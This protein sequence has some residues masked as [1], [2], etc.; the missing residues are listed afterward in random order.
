[1]AICN[2]QKQGP[3][4]YYPEVGTKLAPPAIYFSQ[5]D[6]R[7]YH[8]K[9]HYYYRSRPAEAPTRI[10]VQ[11]FQGARQAST[12]LYYVGSE[13][14]MLHAYAQSLPWANSH[15]QAWAIVSRNEH[16]IARGSVNTTSRCA[17]SRRITSKTCSR[18]PRLLV[19]G[20]L[21][22]PHA[23]AAQRTRP[24]RITCLGSPRL[25]AVGAQSL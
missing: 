6:Y 25:A 16:I 10:P 22:M 2:C 3:G 4:R 24:P 18:R 13:A 5:S 9:S 11:L 19:R 12:G 21:C 23:Q 1:M 17:G 14:S 8:H 7:Y 15:F 20:A